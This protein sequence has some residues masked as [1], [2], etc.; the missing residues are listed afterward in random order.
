[1]REKP[2][3]RERFLKGEMKEEA[4]TDDRVLDISKLTL[5]F[6][7]KRDRNSLGG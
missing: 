2:R 7:F 4:L 1:V 3:E 5:V 6:S